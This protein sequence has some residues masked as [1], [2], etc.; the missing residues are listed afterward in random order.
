MTGAYVAVF[1]KSWHHIDS[2]V[3]S[4][5]IRDNM[6]PLLET[7]FNGEVKKKT[8]TVGI[9]CHLLVNNQALKKFKKNGANVSTKREYEDE[10][11]R[12]NLYSY[13]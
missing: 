5:V 12:K 2:Y 7:I 3:S 13:E 11:Q 9:N 8:R 1:V 6:T 4:N 10:S